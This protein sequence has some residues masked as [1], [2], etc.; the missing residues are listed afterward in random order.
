MIIGDFKQAAKFATLLMSLL[1]HCFYF[2]N[3]GQRITNANENLF[4]SM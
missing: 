2:F 4:N 1:I 3:Q